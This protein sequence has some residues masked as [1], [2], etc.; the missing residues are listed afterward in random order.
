MNPFSYAIDFHHRKAAIP[1]DGKAKV[2]FLHSNDLARYIVA[3]LE[4]DR[5]PEYSA[6][7]GDRMSWG[8]LLG[9]AE[10]VTGKHQPA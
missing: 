4:Q 6:F 1:G 5:W 3:M 7:A 2:A 8:E 9:V 10:E